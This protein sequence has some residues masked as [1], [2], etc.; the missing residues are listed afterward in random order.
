[1]RPG[2]RRCRYRDHGD[3]DAIGDQPVL[4][5]GFE[6]A[7]WWT[8]TERCSSIR[9]R[10]GTCRLT[11]CTKKVWQSHLQSLLISRG[12]GAEHVV[13][14]HPLPRLRETDRHPRIVPIVTLH[15]RADRPL[16]LEWTAAALSM[17]ALSPA[18]LACGHAAGAVARRIVAVAGSPAASVI[19][20]PDRDGVCGRAGPVVHRR[21]PLEVITTAIVGMA[22]P[23][24]VWLVAY[25]LLLATRPPGIGVVK[26]WSEL[27]RDY[28][29]TGALLLVVSSMVPATA[30]FALSYQ[31]RHRSPLKQQDKG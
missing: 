7:I 14:W 22:V 13:S 6:F 4:P 5:P 15:D 28:R 20:Q 31:P 23:I 29:L 17:Q 12:E 25:E 1:M 30:F 26:A 8:R 11:C 27:C 21:G 2:L 18:W 9:T 3:P 19:A 24:V 16:V 10:S